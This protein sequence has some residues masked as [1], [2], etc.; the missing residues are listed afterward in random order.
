MCTLLRN[1]WQW[2]RSPFHR[3]TCDLWRTWHPFLHFGLNTGWTYSSP[4]WAG[5]Y[6]LQYSQWSQISNKTFSNETSIGIYVQEKYRGIICKRMSDYEV[7]AR[8][9]LRNRHSFTSFAVV[10][11]RNFWQRLVSG[12]QISIPTIA[13]ALSGRYWTRIRCN[14]KLAL[15]LLNG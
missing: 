6:C 15:N 9:E 5:I 4:N 3:T 11:E 14:S 8:L 13:I 7:W 2:T 12:F 1:C 10:K